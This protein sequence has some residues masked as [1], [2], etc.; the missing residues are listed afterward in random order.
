MSN[1]GLCNMIFAMA[2]VLNEDGSSLW[3]GISGNSI[4]P[5]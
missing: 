1:F 4:V 2:G 5:G 3:F